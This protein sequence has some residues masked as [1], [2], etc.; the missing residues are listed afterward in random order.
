MARPPGLEPVTLWSE[1]K[2]SPEI[3]KK[4]TILQGL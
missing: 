2:K 4:T 3:L 1:A